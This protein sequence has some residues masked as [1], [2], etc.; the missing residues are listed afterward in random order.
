MAKYTITQFREQFPN[1]DACLD[2]L[3]KSK[4][5]DK[6]GCPEC[7]VES[8]FTRVKGRR[9]YQCPIC[10]HQIYP[11]ADTV[12]HKT[13]TPLTYWFYA[14]Y[15]FTTTRNGVAAKQLERQLDICYKTALRMAHQIKTLMSEDTIEKLGGVVMTDEAYFGMLA[16]NRHSK[17]A[18]K[19]FSKAPK[20]AV[21]GLM[22]KGGRVRT[23]IIRDNYKSGVSIGDI[24]K[25]N[26]DP[27]ATLVTDGAKAYLKMENHFEKHVVINHHLD[28][29][30]KDGFTTNNIENY[31]S[32]L[33]R[34]IKGT[35]I[36]VSREHFLKYANE[37]SFR[38][39]H[40][41]KPEKMLEI[42]LANV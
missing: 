10:S 3:F 21:V 30:V 32:T 6:T 35:H 38:Y 39:M 11:T 17:D 33:K 25:T 2:Y 19:V 31:W 22:E 27:S 34:M 1:D 16:K 14:I 23:E 26:V 13:T 37:N 24:V 20:I 4:F 15:L 18:L 36:H 40:R 41:D 28:Q 12:F 7:S 42:I 29:Y 9:S 5:G 8:K